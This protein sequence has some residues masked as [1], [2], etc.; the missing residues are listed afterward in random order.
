MSTGD[1]GEDSVEASAG[2]DKNSEEGTIS[3]VVTR[4]C[5]EN[6]EQT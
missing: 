5:G 2:N 1:T 3:D 6:I 4:T